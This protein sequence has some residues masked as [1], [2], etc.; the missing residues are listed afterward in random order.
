ML[1]NAALERAG[2]EAAVSHESLRSRMSPRAPA[3]YTRKADKAKVE[4][5]REELHRDDHPQEN[6]LN[7]VMWRHQK[8]VS[9]IRDVS[10][11][12]MVDRVR[13]RFWL[14]DESPARTQER[15]ASIWRTIHREHAHTGRPLQ[16]PR[17]PEHSY[18]IGRDL[19]EQVA[20]LAEAVERLGQDEHHAGRALNIRLWDRERD[21]GSGMGF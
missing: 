8:D 15:D 2:V 13:D 4:A 12:A 16:G 17:Q 9:N 14:K 5:L 7:T 11:E 6:L 3:V 1:T 10:R 21:Q 19:L 18:P 20:E